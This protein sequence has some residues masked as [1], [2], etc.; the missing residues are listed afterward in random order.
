MERPDLVRLAD[1]A[2]EEL[3]QSGQ[4]ATYSGKL[5]PRALTR[6]KGSTHRFDDEFVL[7][8]LFSERMIALTRNDYVEEVSDEDLDAKILTPSHDRPVMVDIYTDYCRPCNHILPIVY[9]LAEQYRDVL[10]VVK[11]NAS[12]HARFR[13]RFLGP[14]QMTP[15]FLFVRN[16]RPV[17][18]SGRFARLLRQ[19][20]FVA[21]TRAGLERR[22]R[23]VL[24]G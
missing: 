22:I 11:I 13:E 21:S 15:S 1:A 7:E 6:L 8:D 14:V 23:S 19:T 12:K 9:Q 3:V 5:P 10:T 20:A 4:F 2:V 18:T 24:T 17:Q 16:G